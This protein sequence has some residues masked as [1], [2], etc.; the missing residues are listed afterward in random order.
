M[1]SSWVVI[2][3][4]KP[5]LLVR[6]VHGEEILILEN[7][8]KWQL[9]RLHRIIRNPFSAVTG[10]SFDNP[11]ASS[12]FE[13]EMDFILFTFASSSGN[14]ASVLDCTFS[15]S[16]TFCRW[17]PDNKDRIGMWRVVYV[18]RWTGES[19]CMSK[20]ISRRAQRSKAPTVAKL[21]SPWM[22]SASRC[23][24]F[25]YL[26]DGPGRLSMLRHADG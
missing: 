13:F 18:D 24:R 21:W 2:L 23:L 12:F 5:S 6:V 10:M 17:N 14:L 4:C 26:L 15:S 20:S 3:L 19:A 7:W 22:E 25:S 11:S 9:F 1:F 8:G 16:S